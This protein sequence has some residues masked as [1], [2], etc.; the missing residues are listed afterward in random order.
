MLKPYVFVVCEKVVLDSTG[1]A[2]LISLFTQIEGQPG[3]P[4]ESIPKNA[5]I[6]LP[7]FV[8]TSWE[9]ETEDVGKEFIQIVQI[10]YPDGT[11]FQ[12]QQQRFKPETGK[13]H[14]QLTLNVLGF[15]VGQ[16]GI[17]Q[18]KMRL[19]QAGTKLFESDPIKINVRVHKPSALPA[20]S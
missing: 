13:T 2:S 12:E 19:E 18:V 17:Y 4:S 11:L 16:Q 3:P 15:P 9:Y 14:Y 6:P 5:V 1:T 8:F 20:N 10:F 7:W